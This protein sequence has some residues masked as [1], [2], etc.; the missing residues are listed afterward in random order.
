[1]G[2]GPF[3]WVARGSREGPLGWPQGAEAWLR[4]EAGGPLGSDWEEGA[5]QGLEKEEKGRL[6]LGFAGPFK[7]RELYSKSDG[8]P[9][10]GL[11]SG[12]DIIPGPGLKGYFSCRACREWIERRKNPEG[13]PPPAPAS[14][15]VLLPPGDDPWSA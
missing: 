11:E 1:M 3:P 2:E 5:A 15:P 14:A 4:E 8:K 13:C 7:E 12:R 6:W 9:L 10:R